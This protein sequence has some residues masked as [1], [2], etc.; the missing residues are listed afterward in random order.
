MTTL[1][2][3]VLACAVVLGAVAAASGD[4]QDD[5]AKKLVGKWTATLKVGEKEVPVTLQFDKDGKFRLSGKVDGKDIKREGTY[6]LLSATRLEIS[7]VSDGKTKSEKSDF[8]L[9]GDTLELKSE[10][11]ETEKFTR[12]KPK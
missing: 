2:R 4:A 10:A 5:A 1:R 3:A 9:T 11:G 7:I 8:K 6:K 12:A